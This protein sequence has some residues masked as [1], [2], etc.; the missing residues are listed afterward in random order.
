MATA[1]ANLSDFPLRYKS[2]QLSKAL[3]H[4]AIP[5]IWAHCNHIIRKLTF[6]LLESLR[7]L[8]PELRPDD[9]VAAD[10]GR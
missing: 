3:E 4:I 2:C 6:R 10:G 9:F 7:A 8:A 1:L 5:G